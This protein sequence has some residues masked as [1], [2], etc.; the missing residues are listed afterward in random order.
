[1]RLNC[2]SFPRSRRI[3]PPNKGSQAELVGSL[4]LRHVFPI[5]KPAGRGIIKQ[6]RP[7]EERERG[8]ERETTRN[9][10]KKK[11]QKKRE[12]RVTYS[13]SSVGNQNRQQNSGLKYDGKLHAPTFPEKRTL[14][15]EI[16][17]TAAA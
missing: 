12:E 10:S 15:S 2:I 11:T 17:K 1:M 14:R 9:E 16:A 4:F 5:Q 8:R 7:L 13:S 6:L 3:E